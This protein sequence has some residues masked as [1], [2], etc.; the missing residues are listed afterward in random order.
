MWAHR[1]LFNCRKA[2]MVSYKAS[3]LCW[4]TKE[5]AK[6]AAEDVFTREEITQSDHK[7]SISTIL[8]SCGFG[9][10]GFARRWA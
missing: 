10:T 6:T 7:T 5:L 8:R 3:A 1:L 4:K 2:F 9:G